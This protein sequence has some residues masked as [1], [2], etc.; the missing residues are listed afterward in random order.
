MSALPLPEILNKSPAGAFWSPSTGWLL[1]RGG[2][3]AGY[4]SH[5]KTVIA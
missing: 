3:H 2:N 1:R 4:C 5:I